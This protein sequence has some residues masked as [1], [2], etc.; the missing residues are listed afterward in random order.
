MPVRFR[1]ASRAP[2]PVAA[3][4]LLPAIAALFRDEPFEG[5]EGELEAFLVTGEMLDGFGAD[6]PGARLWRQHGAK[7]VTAWAV[8]HAGT[9]PSVWWVWDAPRHP[10]G[11]FRGHSWDGK[12]VEPR[13]R[14]GGVGR[15]AHEVSA[16]FPEY[17]F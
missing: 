16:Y 14:L 12:L 5:L 10:A 13:K 7:I 9:R 4:R 15:P 2:G 11:Q 17:R 3:T 8:R 6:G 1:F